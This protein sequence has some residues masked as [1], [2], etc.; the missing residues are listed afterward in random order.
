VVGSVFVIRRRE[1]KTPLVG[2]SSEQAA[3]GAPLTGA[4]N[5]ALPLIRHAMGI[6]IKEKLQLN[7]FNLKQGHFTTAVKGCI[8]SK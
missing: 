4:V 2:R 7:I 6:N 5:Y 3:K 1:T 8:M